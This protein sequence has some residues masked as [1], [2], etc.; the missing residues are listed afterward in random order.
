MAAGN[1]DPVHWLKLAQT[2]VAEARPREAK[3]GV[4]Q[5]LPWRNTYINFASMNSILGSSIG[6]RSAQRRTR[7]PPCRIRSALFPVAG[8]RRVRLQ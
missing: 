6:K 3:S 1:R 8:A 7:P 2:L 5:A 4:Y